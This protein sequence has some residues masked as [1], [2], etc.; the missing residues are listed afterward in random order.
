MTVHDKVPGER[1]SEQENVCVRARA[2][3]C[4]FADVHLH[5]CQSVQGE[6]LQLPCPRAHETHVT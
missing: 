1:A 3:L 2:R 4:M 6:M 5:E